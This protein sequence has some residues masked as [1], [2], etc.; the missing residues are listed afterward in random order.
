MVLGLCIFLFW[1]RQDDFFTGES[2]IMGKGHIFWLEGFKLKK[3]L[4][5]FVYYKHTAFHFTRLWWTG[6]MWISCGLLWC[7]YQLFILSFWRHPFTAEDPL[8]S[9]W[10]DDT[11]LQIC[12]DE[13]TNSSTSWI[14]WSYFFLWTVP[15]SDL[16]QN[17]PVSESFGV[18]IKVRNDSLTELWVIFS[19]MSN[20]K[21]TFILYSNI[22]VN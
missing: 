11:F 1:F 3:K 14:A 15:L 22:L 10:C 19:F 7:F 6:V 12:S 13:E 2:N 18:I 4:H 5:G 21:L 16:N 20:S 17:H 9:K 8:L